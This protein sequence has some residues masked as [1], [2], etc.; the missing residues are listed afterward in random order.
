MDAVPWRAEVHLTPDLVG[1]ILRRQLP[2][3][4]V[5][6][7]DFLNEGWDSFAFLADGQWVF[8]FPKRRDTEQPFVTSMH[9]LEELH[10]RVPV[11]VP[12]PEHWG[13]PVEGYPFRFVGYRFLPGFHGDRTPIP[14]RQQQSN[15]RRLGEFLSALHS[16]PVD[17]ALALG[18]R[19]GTRDHAEEM[20]DEVRHL[21]DRLRDRLP[22]PLRDRCLPFVD[23]TVERPPPP[24]GRCCLTHGDLQAEHILLDGEGAVCGIIDFGDASIAEPA[25]DYVG[26]CAWQ[27]WDFARAA[28]A[29]AGVNADDT[30]RKRILFM[31]RC[32]G[33]IGVGW[34][35][36][37]DQNRVRFLHNVFG[38]CG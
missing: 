3:L 26:L 1:Q 33:L 30:T 25:G 20:L 31:A 16:F 11:P 2:S 14:P 17:R 24:D 35:D 15:A 13:C 32:L 19:Q 27:S 6:N 34:A 18:V 8:L 12:R 10:G 9:L 21:A 4:H 36:W 7:V 29:A 28:L 22:A 38:E 37:Q 5:Q 23:G